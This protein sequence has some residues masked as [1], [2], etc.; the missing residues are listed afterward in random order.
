[1]KRK[2]DIGLIVK[3]DDKEYSEE[4]TVLLYKNLFTLLAEGNNVKIDQKLLEKVVRTIVSGLFKT[5][6]ETRTS[7][8]LDINKLSL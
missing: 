3:F 6:K 5:P 2:K 8:N 1:M 4:E 7:E